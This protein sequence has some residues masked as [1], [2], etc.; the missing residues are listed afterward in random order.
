MRRRSLAGLLALLLLATACA[1]PQRKDTSVLS[2]PAATE[3]SA[4]SVVAQYN[5]VRARADEVLDGSVLPQIEGGTLLDIDQGAYFVSVRVDKPEGHARVRLEEPERVIA[6]RFAAYPMWFVVLA[7]D[8]L[9]GHKRVAVFERADSVSPWLMTMAPATTAEA[10]L[11]PV[12][13]DS[14]GAAVTVGADDTSTT[15]VS[16]REVLQRYAGAL[17]PGDAEDEEFFD[18]DAF[19]AQTEKFQQNQESLPFATFQQTWSAQEPEFAL[20]VEGGGLLVFGTVTRRDAYSVQTNSYIDWNDDADTA[21]YLPGRVYQSATLD[22][23][24]QLLLFVPPEGEGKPRLIGQY[25]GV[26]DG[27][28]S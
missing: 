23:I 20:R 6:P 4:R 22:Y 17:A 13:V 5:A 1:I 11:P 26:V 2:K 28:G 8:R 9:G 7:R 21:A 15:S 3:V 12:V 16:P 25:G 10:G 24:H 14:D 18:P 27:Q 19:L